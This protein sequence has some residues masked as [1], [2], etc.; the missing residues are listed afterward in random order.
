MRLETFEDVTPTENSNSSSLNDDQL[1]ELVAKM[2]DS[3]I[4][5]TTE[6]K[7]NILQELID[8][9]NQLLLKQQQ[10]LRKM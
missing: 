1:K 4:G 8:R 2:T 9:L 5:E 3:N 7:H 6:E 10:R